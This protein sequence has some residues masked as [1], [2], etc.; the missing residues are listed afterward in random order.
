MADSLI[1]ETLLAFSTAPESAYNTNPVTASLF[2]S[3]LTR[4][5]GFY[6]PSNEATN[7]LGAIGGGST[8]PTIVRNNFREATQIQVQDKVNVNTFAVQ[9]RRLLGAADPTPAG[10]DIIE[11]SKAFRHTFKEMDPANGRQLPSTSYISIN[12]GADFIFCG[13]VGNSVTISQTG[14]EDPTFDMSMNASGLTK[15]ISVVYPSF[16]T[17]SA[18]AARSEMYGADTQCSYTD[19]AGTLSLTAARR[20]RSFSWA[21]NNNLDTGDRRPGA[22]AIN[23]ACPTDGWY[24]DY[25]L[26]TDT[27][28]SVTM[29]INHD[30]NLREHALAM[31]KTP[32]TNLFFLLRG[33]CIPTTTADNRYSVRIKVPKCYF[34]NPRPVDDNNNAALDIDI[35]P[36][37]DGSSYKGASIIEVV[38]GV[39]TAI[40]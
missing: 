16:G 27:T 36:V 20:L 12:N 39:A 8:Y 22:S 10:P 3:Y 6:V 1:S 7:D 21:H 14:V 40:A 19:S 33:D 9:L 30:G 32:V 5:R 31:S 25:L 18:P 11:A 26:R 28:E 38:N 15:D 17:L 4:S 23:A 34:S 37:V 35:I 24:L 13:C 29:R 2:T